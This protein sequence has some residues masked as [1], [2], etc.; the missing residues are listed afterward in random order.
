M[1]VDT[2]VNCVATYNSISVNHDG[3]IEPCCQYHRDTRT[4]PIKFTEFNKYQNTVQRHMHQ[5]AEAGVQHPGC[6]K[7]W[8]EES[9]GWQ[10]LRQSFN[11]WYFPD[12]SSTVNPDNPIYDVEL[13]LGNFCNLKCIMC[14]PGAS[15]SIAVERSQNFTK[16]QAIGID[17][18]N[19]HNEHFWETPEFWEFSEKLFKDARRVNIT[20]GEPFII[21]EVLRI[22]NCLLPK[23]DTVKLSFN[24]N[25]TKV[26]DK[27][28]DHLRPFNNLIIHVSLEGV[29]AMNDYLRFPSKWHDIL[30]N[31]IKIKKQL[32]KAHVAINHTFQHSS[33]YALPKLMEFC[34]TQEIGLLLTSVQGDRRLTIDS[35]PK[36]D[37]DKFKIWLVNTKHLPEIKQKILNFIDN[38][39]YDPELHKKYIEYVSV[40]DE[41]RGTNY[42]KVFDQE[43]KYVNK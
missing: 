7:C 27:L 42:Y 30:E 25:L 21:P 38:C 39:T 18:R 36:E 6:K 14:Y 34:A 13:R 9:A 35:V 17:V 5:D 37:I 16:F 22:I 29:G 15:S 32:P 12:A 41:I 26:S 11:K 20:G 40:L 1:A 31:F 43:T 3:S 23:K 10:S 2:S 19:V 4:A 33:I 8:S 24:T 28:I